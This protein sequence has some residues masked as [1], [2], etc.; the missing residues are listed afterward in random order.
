V[1]DQAK[2]AIQ[3]FRPRNCFVTDIVMGVPA[4]ENANVSR[5]EVELSG[6]GRRL[7]PEVLSELF[8]FF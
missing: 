3:S 6:F 7:N 2:E 1:R 4:D 8:C 5:P